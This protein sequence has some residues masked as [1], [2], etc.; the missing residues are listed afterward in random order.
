[1][2]STITPLAVRARGHRYRWSAGWFILG[3]TAGGAALGLLLGCLSWLGGRVDL[4]LTARLVTAAAVAVL[5]V[6]ADARLGGLRLAERPR[7][8]D[9]SWVGTFRPWV[10]AGG[11]GLQLG[12]AVSTYVMSNATYVVLICSVVLLS[13]LSAFVVG[14]TFGLCRGLTI[15]VGAGIR[16]PKDLSRVHAALDRL[17]APSLA[18]AV[19]GQ[20]GLVVVCA[21]ALRSPIAA[22]LGVSAA[23]AL[24]AL[25]LRSARTTPQRAV[26][27]AA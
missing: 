4:P 14:A 22:I 15:L 1:M 24:G 9:A 11:Y 27:G 25:C 12:T 5:C 19:V 3:A 6:A 26:V 10:Y 23:I 18:L 7:Q 8:V 21:V 2:L 20:L 16:S 13:P 17:A